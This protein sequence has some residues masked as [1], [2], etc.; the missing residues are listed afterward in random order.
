[1]QIVSLDP[2]EERLV[3]ICSTH[4]G[5]AVRELPFASVVECTLLQLNRFLVGA[6][7]Q[8]LDLHGEVDHM[9]GDRTCQL[10]STW[11][12]LVSE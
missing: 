9:L 6:K 8:L 5:E 4:D 1:M 3:Y 10:E 7:N 11:S 2:S 12:R